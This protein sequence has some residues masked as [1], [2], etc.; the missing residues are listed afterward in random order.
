ME[1]CWILY[2]WRKFNY[3]EAVCFQRQGTLYSLFKFPNLCT[4]IIMAVFLNNRSVDSIKL[5]IYLIYMKNF[6]PFPSVILQLFPQIN[7]ILTYTFTVI[8]LQTIF[9]LRYVYFLHHYGPYFLKIIVAKHWFLVVFGQAPSISLKYI[10]G[11]YVTEHQNFI[12]QVYLCVKFV[13]TISKIMFI[14]EQS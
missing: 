1:F 14:K 5:F 11:F 13:W 4:N 12:S 8:H 10:S 2:C 3:F 6:T 7:N 9:Y